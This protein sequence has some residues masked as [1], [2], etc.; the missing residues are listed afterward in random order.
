M[1]STSGSRQY[2]DQLAKL[3]ASAT[4]GNEKLIA[5]EAVAQR[6]KVEEDIRE[7]QKELRRLNAGKRARIE[8]L[9]AKIET[10][11]PRLGAGRRPAHRH[12]PG[13]RPLRSRPA[14]HR[15]EG[16]LM[17]SNKSLAVLLAVTAAMV[18]IVLALYSGN[19]AAKQEFQPGSLL[20]QGVAPEKIQTISI[21][22]G[23]DTVTLKRQD[24]GFVLA[25]RD[26]Y[27]ASV[28]RINELLLAC[29]E[30]RCRSKVTDA[31][32]NYRELGV[33][34]GAEDAVVVTFKDSAG[35]DAVRPRARQERR[36]RRRVRAAARPERRLRLR[37]HPGD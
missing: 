7:A 11:Q 31:K 30:I 17:I 26:D 3:G 28:N 2:Q 6:K 16:V 18:V 10:Q 1:R 35:R 33:E 14:L 8:A 23:K 34:E 5:G 37:D 27:P 20:I 24:K 4:A 9:G 32:E 29:L 19:R 25:E 21:V 12:R 15:T 36:G 13:R 22:H